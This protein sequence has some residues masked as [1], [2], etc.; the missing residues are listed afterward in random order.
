MTWKCSI[1]AN[2][3]QLCRFSEVNGGRGEK[4]SVRNLSSLGW[5]TLVV[6]CFS[7]CLSS[8]FGKATMLSISEKQQILH[9]IILYFVQIFNRNLIIIT[10]EHS[11][12]SVV[13]TLSWLSLDRRTLVGISSWMLRAS[14]LINTLSVLP[15]VTSLHTML[16]LLCILV[17]VLFYQSSYMVTSLC[18]RDAISSWANLGYLDSLLKLLCQNTA[19]L[20]N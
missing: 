6:C 2:R 15:A 9:K 3:L 10:L 14:M 16:H 8:K 11:V 7:L 4:K 13:R 18:N 12:L 20:L 5:E 17:P 19:S 1:S